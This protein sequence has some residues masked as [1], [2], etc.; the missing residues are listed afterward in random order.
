MLQHWLAVLLSCK[1]LLCFASLLAAG[2]KLLDRSWH[3]SSALGVCST[4]YHLYK[5]E[6]PGTLGQVWQHCA[7]A[8]WLS[9]LLADP[10]ENISCSELDILHEHCITTVVLCLAKGKSD[11]QYE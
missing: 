8:L 9:E 3:T 2:R 4:A 7:Q 5:T 10:E 6:D 1:V 11:I